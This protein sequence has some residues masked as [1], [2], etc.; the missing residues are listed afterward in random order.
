MFTMSESMD[1]NGTHLRM[2]PYTKQYM[3]VAFSREHR[4]KINSLF[5]I[6]QENLRRKQYFFSGIITFFR[7]HL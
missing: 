3:D 2:I 5:V 4:P 7:A 6:V 1:R